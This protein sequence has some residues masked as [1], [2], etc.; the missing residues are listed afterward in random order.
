MEHILNHPSLSSGKRI[1][2]R[3]DFKN[4]IL[5]ENKAYLSQ[6]IG[7][8][9]S[10]IQDINENI[11]DMGMR[12]IVSNA[13]TVTNQIRRIIHTHWPQSEQDSL[14]VLQKCGVAIMKAIEEKDDLKAVLQACQQNIE[15][16]SGDQGK[17][18]NQ[19]AG[20]ES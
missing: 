9:L 4:F 1:D 16:I 3:M 7:D 15:N 14:L 11:D 18:V 19:I 6:K 20:S 13:Q 5:E 12:Q 10:A 17:P 8:L 2:I